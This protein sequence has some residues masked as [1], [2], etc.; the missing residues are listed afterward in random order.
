MSEDKYLFQNY[1][2][3]PAAFTHGRGVRLWD[4]SGKEYL[5]FLAGI[6]VSSLGHSHPRL[7]RALTRQVERSLV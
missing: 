1:V 3:A 7:V 4:E 5:D 6:A 2:R